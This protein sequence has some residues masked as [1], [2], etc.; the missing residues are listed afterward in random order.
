MGT[1]LAIYMF[2][3]TVGMISHFANHNNMSF[4]DAIGHDWSLSGTFFLFL[5]SI[6]VCAFPA[7]LMCYHFWLISRGE[8]TREY[9]RSHKFRDQ[10]RHRPFD[11]YN[12]RANLEAVLCRPRPPTYMQFKMS[13]VEGDQRFNVAKTNKMVPNG[14]VEMTD[15][16]NRKKH[17]VAGPNKTLQTLKKGWADLKASQK[18]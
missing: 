8:T 10:D 2:G 6:F 18:L 12:L 14:A 13:H 5:Y 3:T 1:V 7:S 17:E 16:K 11:L 15:L 4:G 9:L